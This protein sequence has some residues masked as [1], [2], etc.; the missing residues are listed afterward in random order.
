MSIKTWLQRR[1]GG[2]VTTTSDIGW[3]ILGGDRRDPGSNRDWSSLVGD[4]AMNAVASSV[5]GW[6]ARTLPESPAVVARTMP[7]GEDEIERTH[8]ILDVLRNPNPNYS[9]DQLMGATTRE[10]VSHGNAYWRIVRGAKGKGQAVQLYWLPQSLISCKGGDNSNNFI[11]HYEFNTGRGVENIDP[12]DIVHFRYGLDPLTMGRTGLSPLRALYRS[13]FVLNA[14]ENFEATMLVNHGAPGMYLSLGADGGVMT[15]DEARQWK[16]LIMES[17]TGDHVGEP[18]VGSPGSTLTPFGFSPEQLALTSM[19]DR[20]EALVCAATGVNA[21]VLGL[22]VGLE[23]STYSNMEE[24][25]RSAYEKCVIPMKGSIAQD[26]T[27]QLFYRD[28][29]KPGDTS[30]AYDYSK[31]QCLQ[32]NEAE[33]VKTLTTAAGGPY[34]TPNEAREKAGLDPLP[35]EEMDKV[36][37]A[38]QPPQLGQDGKPVPPGQDEDETKDKENSIDP[39]LK[40]FLVGWNR[41]ETGQ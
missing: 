38:Q 31:V 18:I 33:K 34:L 41:K 7:D 20:P 10:L 13:L 9:G 35:D 16:A 3:T 11:D 1:F 29:E 23:H 32:E 19:L 40:A 15:I 25:Q 8:P 21:V 14:G 39:V 4:P 27:V 24:A 26:I 2:Q 17:T 6:I 28:F 30:V 12:L 5:I 37:K 22:K 36:R